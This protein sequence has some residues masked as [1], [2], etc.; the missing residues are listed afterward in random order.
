MKFFQRDPELFQATSVG[1]PNPDYLIGPGDEII[2]MLWGETQFREVLQVD[3][4]GFIFIPEIGRVFVNGLNLTLLESKLFRVFSQSYASLALK[5]FANYFLDVSLGNLRP[6]RIQVLGEVA[7]HG[8]YTVS[9]SATLFSAL[10]YFN[11]P[12][13]SGSLRDIHLIRDGEKMTSIDFYDFLLTGKN[14]LIKNCN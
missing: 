8:A 9:P 1:S 3:R 7:Q 11:G 2:V 14:R 12:T 5:K 13:T 10:Y 6:M 4:E